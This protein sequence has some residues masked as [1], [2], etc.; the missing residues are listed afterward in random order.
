MRLPLRRFIL[1]C[2]GVLAGCGSLR[3]PWQAPEVPVPTKW[4]V[5]TDASIREPDSWWKNFDDPQLDALVDQALRAN[6]DFAVAAIRVRRAQLQAGLVDT[7]QTPA[8][9][10][11][12]SVVATR[13]F[14]PPATN[15]SGGVSAA[16]SFEVDLWGKLASQRDAARWEAQATEADCQA[17]ALSL[18]G[19]TTHLYWQ[20]AYLNQLLTLNAGDIDYA[21]QTLT[22]VRAKYAAGALSALNTAQAE[23]DLATQEASRTQ[24]IQQRVETRHALAI[25]LNLPPESDVAELSELSNAPMPPVAAG[26]PAEILANRPDMNAAEWRL[27]ESLANVD[28]ARTSFYPAFT[29]TGSL[30]TASTTLV[31]LLRN[32]IATLG[33]GLSLPFVQWNTMQLSIRVSETQYEE[34]VVN[35]RQRLYTALAEVENSLSARTQLLAEEEKLRLAVAHARRAESIAK[36]RFQSGFTDLQQWLYAQ[37]GLRNAER[38]LVLNRLNQLN[39]MVS[40]YKSLGLGARTEPLSCARLAG[41]Q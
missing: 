6:N 30:G 21:R 36:F 14:D 13:T 32:P 1:G 38:S 9:A 17:F 3:A 31:N 10:V 19:S 15:H 18:V 22:L 29:L 37:A 27:R 25:L 34:A 41:S 23:L 2:V 40:L 20:L 39:N 8:V 4:S 12:A 24:L 16:L 28:V 33:A 35:Y 7:N 11:G 26:I 5:V